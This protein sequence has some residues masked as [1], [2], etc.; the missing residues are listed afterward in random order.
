MLFQVNRLRQSL[1]Y[2]QIGLVRCHVIS[3]SFLEDKDRKR[4]DKDRDK[5]K[6]RD[7]DKDKEKEKEKVKY[8][9][10]DPS[11]LLSFVYFDQS[12]TGYLLDKDAEEILHTMGLH[13]SRSQV[14]TCC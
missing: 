8:S 10:V 7:K 5:R 13:L 6:D 3:V 1:N 9:T 11:L 14:I 2:L 12:H 4:E